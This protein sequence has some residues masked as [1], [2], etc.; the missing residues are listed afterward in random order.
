LLGPSVSTNISSRDQESESEEEEEEEEQDEDAEV[1]PIIRLG[2][3]RRFHPFVKL[4]LGLWPFGES[5]KEL[6]L[7][8]KI[9]EIVKVQQNQWRVD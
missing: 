6:G 7:M 1:A 2:T 9:Y 3:R 8:G 5:F 4:L